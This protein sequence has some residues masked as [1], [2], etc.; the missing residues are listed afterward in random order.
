[1]IKGLVF[2]KDGTLFHY[3]GTWSVWT[4]LVLRE[5]SSGDNALA[6]QLGALVGYDTEH[7]EF[8]PGS[9]VVGGS[10]QEINEAWAAHLS[11]WSVEDIDAVAVKHLEQLPSLPVCDL[12]ALFSGMKAKGLKLGL[13]TNDYEQG[14]VQQLQQVEILELFDFVAGFD[15]GYGAKPAADPLLAFGQAVGLTMEEVAMVGDSA[16]DL[17]AGRAAH[18][19]MTIGVL[20]GPAL[21]E[22][23]VG[24][25]DVVLEDIEKIPA[26]LKG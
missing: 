9:L 7:R 1:M 23:L 2:D 12:V 21:R 8:L 3:G 15:S 26:H 20:T 24:L 13:V 14:A 6:Q 22:D 16:H 17:E 5:L 11:N 10:A 18:V 25:A 19:G 4:D